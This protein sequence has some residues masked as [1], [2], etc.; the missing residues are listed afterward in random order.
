MADRVVRA[1][2]GRQFSRTQSCWYVVY[3]E[4]ALED[5]YRKLTEYQS[6]EISEGFKSRFRD[7]ES[8][9]KIQ[10]FPLPEGYHDMLI[11]VRYSEATVKTYESQMRN[12]LGWIHP[13]TAAEINEALINAYQLYLAEKRK[14][15]ISTQNTAINAIKFYLEKVQR[16][17]RK[18][19]YI[20]RPIKN[21]QL[22]RVLSQ[23]EVKGM[24]EVTSN[25]KHRCML[26]LLYSAGL[27]MSEL[28][29]LR[30]KDFD[31]NRMQLF[32]DGGKGNKDRITLLS[33]QVVEYVRFYMSLYHPVEWLFEGPGRHRYSP[34][35]VNQ[36]VHRA[37]NLAGIKKRVSAH[38]LRHSFATHLLEQNTDIR[39]IQVLM[40]HESSKTTERYTHVTTRGF[41]KIKSPLDGL[42]VSLMAQNPSAE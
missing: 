35:S 11:R 16:G 41:S 29:N 36:V 23:E 32:V 22:P 27:R 14:V 37:A 38:T 4:K 3:S 7:S 28:L 24:I 17:E 39:Y 10:S 13:R 18:E 20:D 30:W 21:V 2:P 12:F 34:R 9:V 26:L 8:Q 25:P 6:V 1:F 40:G 31:T 15:S 5:L 19:Y 33:G 42:G